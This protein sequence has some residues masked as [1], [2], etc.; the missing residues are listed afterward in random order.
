MEANSKLP[1]EER[2]Q[3]LWH[4]LLNLLVP[5]VLSVTWVVAYL[6]HELPALHEILANA[7]TVFV[8]VLYCDIFQNGGS[9]FE[10]HVP[11]APRFFPDVALYMVVRSTVDNGYW[12]FL[13]FGL[14]MM[15][16]LYF[17]TIW[18][19]RLAS[20]SRNAV[21]LCQFCYLAAIC[22][23]AIPGYRPYLWTYV[24]TF[25]TG[26]LIHGMLLMIFYTYLLRS[27]R[28]KGW[29]AGLAIL[30]AVGA[31]SDL[32]FLLAYLLPLC[33]CIVLQRLLDKQAPK[34]ILK[35]VVLIPVSAF[36]GIYLK[37]LATPDTTPR[38]LDF[39]QSLERLWAV[40]MMAWLMFKQNPIAVSLQTIFYVLILWRALAWLIARI[41][42]RV[43]EDHPFPVWPVT[44]L[45]SASALVAFMA[46]RGLIPVDE[47][48]QGSRFIVSISW[49]AMLVPWL[50][51]KDTLKNTRYTTLG[52]ASLSI[53]VLVC[54]VNFNP[55]TRELKSSFK[56]EWYV[57][58]DSYLTEYENESG[59]KLKH[60]VASY[61]STKTTMSLS[62]HEL[63][64]GQYDAELL[65]YNCI[66]SSRWY[67]ESYDFAVLSQSDEDKRFLKNLI[68]VVGEPEKTYDCGVISLL[69]FAPGQVNS[70]SRQIHGLSVTGLAQMEPG[71]GSL[72]KEDWTIFSPA[73]D[74]PEHIAAAGPNYLLLDAGEYEVTFTCLVKA[75]V[76]GG[77]FFCDVSTSSG[78]SLTK[79]EIRV[80]ATTTER[81]VTLR[82]EVSELMVDDVYKFRVWKNGRF[83]LTLTN[84]EVTKSR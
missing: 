32:F 24:A 2:W 84:I 47:A 23:L 56:P 42:G 75:A 18:F 25:H 79:E 30:S 73:D 21:L 9:W 76:D 16:I 69:V 43:Q 66:N 71:V 74:R 14:A 58:F 29:W 57:A 46:L 41:Q 26:I 70:T 3:R 36:V 6:S 44:I 27:P 12:G 72:R 78:A 54:S 4:Y 15:L 40:P 61:W 45:I 60:G 28:S 64:I 13:L 31:A 83:D 5:L 81:K 63:E 65:R 55:A 62:D 11:H 68:R 33:L 38:L 1:P 7:D 19:A 77:S 17:V 39:S 59:R 34:F 20:G 52:L 80:S 67:Q 49:L 50:P 53:L 37:N 48:L 10:W 22:F 35:L 82:F 51:I 8:D